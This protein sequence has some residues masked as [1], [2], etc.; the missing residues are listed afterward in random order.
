M[1]K[2]SRAME[3]ESQ[4][5]QCVVCAGR[6]WKV[7]SGRT[8]VVMHLSNSG[9]YLQCRHVSYLIVIGICMCVC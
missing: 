1:L 8:V 5:K 9:E 7:L 3:I 4:D 2:D 6:K